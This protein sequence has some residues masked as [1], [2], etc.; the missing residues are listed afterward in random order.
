MGPV[1]IRDTISLTANPLTR[2]FTILTIDAALHLMFVWEPWTHCGS[3]RSTCRCGWYANSIRI[4]IRW[5]SNILWFLLLLLSILSTVNSWSFNSNNVTGYMHDYNNE[6]TE[7]GLGPIHCHWRFHN[8]FLFI[9]VPVFYFC[10]PFSRS[11]TLIV[12]I[13]DLCSCCC[14]CCCCCY[15]PCTPFGL[16]HVFVVAR[17]LFRV[18]MKIYIINT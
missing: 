5:R 13:L 12:L 7:N 16:D 14:R 2:Q 15:S 3:Q 18:M 6:T 9:S 1:F 10:L 4:Q 17:F 11:Q 8:K